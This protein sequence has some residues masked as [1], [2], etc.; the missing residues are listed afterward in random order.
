M[1]VLACFT[2]TDKP[3]EEKVD[4][5]LTEQLK[6]T[7]DQ[8]DKKSRQCEQLDAEL[9]RLKEQ[10]LVVRP[11]ELE[12]LKESHRQELE[13]L[14]QELANERDLHQEASR[15]L[16]G[17]REQRDAKVQML[18][19]ELRNLSDGLAQKEED[20][21]NIQFSMVELQNRCSDQGALVE[22]NADA[23]QKASEELAEKEEALEQAVQ[24]QQELRQQMSAASTALQGQVRQLSQELEHCQAAKSTA[25]SALSRLQDE[26]ASLAAQLLQ[27]NTEMESLRERLHE[28]EAAAVR[29]QTQLEDEIQERAGAGSDRRSTP[30]PGADH[31]AGAA[32]SFC[33]A[34]PLVPSVLI[35][36]EIDLG[37]ASSGRATLTVSPWQTSSDY[38]SVVKEFLAH[39][40]V[41]P[42]FEKAVVLYL[43]D[44]ERSA[45]T[46]P[47]LVK[48]SLTEIYSR[49]G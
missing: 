43:E 28:Q 41:K 34:T 47:L 36:A 5:W 45:T 7:R 23:F 48:A 40:R 26:N 46:F 22:E 11:E 3:A 35:A 13:R 38:N 16:Q 15:L 1:S 33:E 21:L 31:G 19:E 20:M 44:L 24:R 4:V 37:P 12:A 49:Y 9:R 39:H 29:R 17:Q 42:I 32:P 25:Q 10:R 2:R 18:Q 8:L 27:A 14:S 30:E 6:F